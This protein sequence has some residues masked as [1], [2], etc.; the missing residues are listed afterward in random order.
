MLAIRRIVGWMTAAWLLAAAAA[1]G[2]Q[3][4]RLPAEDLWLEPA[5]EDVYRVGTAATGEA[6]EQ[7]G[8][9]RSLA[10]DGAGNLHPVRET[11]VPRNDFTLSG[12]LTISGRQSPGATTKRGR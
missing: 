11:C 5:I 10:F 8:R 6:W 3:T 2:Q 4:I 9:I 12:R 1:V 7:F